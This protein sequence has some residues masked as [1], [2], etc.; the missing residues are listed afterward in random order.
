MREQVCTFLE[1]QAFRKHITCK[2][3]WM[4][5]NFSSRP[6][7]GRARRKVSTIPKIQFVR[8]NRRLG[9]GGMGPMD[10]PTLLNLNAGS[11]L[12]RGWTEIHQTLV[13]HVPKFMRTSA[14][15]PLKTQR[16][17]LFSRHT[18]LLL[19][20]YSAATPRLLRHYS[21]NTNA[22]MNGKTQVFWITPSS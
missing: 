22:E 17:P 15:A 16:K 11:H 13:I 6:E 14:T 5:E 12:S 20:H 21:A 3:L 19:R 7:L 4:V 1:P 18:L 9:S 2:K 8:P 10:L